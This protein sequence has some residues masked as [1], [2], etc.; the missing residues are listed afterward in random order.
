MSKNTGRSYA[1]YAPSA[2]FYLRL[3][4]QD[5]P[6]KIDVPSYI[7]GI[8]DRFLNVERLNTVEETSTL[9]EIVCMLR[10]MYV[11]KEI[12]N[13]WLYEADRRARINRRNSNTIHQIILRTIGQ[14]D[15]VRRQ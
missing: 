9:R 12:H 6:L 10:K 7:F 11:N 1:V 8:I 2:H 14:I 4:A 13:L 5:Y 15:L 3:N